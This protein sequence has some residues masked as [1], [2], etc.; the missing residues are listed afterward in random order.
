MR[1][2]QHTSGRTPLCFAWPP[3]SSPPPRALSPGPSPGTTL[4]SALSRALQPT[5]GASSTG[6]PT[7]VQNGSG[8][9]G[10]PAVATAG[11]PGVT[12]WVPPASSPP[13]AG[14]VVPRRSCALCRARSRAAGAPEPA[15]AQP[16]LRA[17]WSGSPLASDPFGTNLTAVTSELMR[18]SIAAHAHPAAAT[19]R[20]GSSVPPAQRT[21]VGGGGSSAGGTSG[22]FFMLFAATLAW[23]ALSLPAMCRR[24]RLI[25]ERGVPLASCW[26]WIAPVSRS[27][28][29][30]L[31]AALIRAACQIH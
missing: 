17:P 15:Q 1:A 31:N 29:L 12:P 5:A 26:C 7:R 22:V 21:P 4:P 11:S 2:Q 24:L 18:S 10:G 14:S 28:A 8:G 25:R 23:L 30:P 3:R 19:D 9:L 16:A 13:L 20:S 27:S 6:A